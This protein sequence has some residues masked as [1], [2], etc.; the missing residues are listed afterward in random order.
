MSW[1]SPWSGSRPWSVLQLDLAQ[2]VMDICNPLEITS[3]I[4]PN[5]FCFNITKKSCPG[6]LLGQVPDLGV[7]YSWTSPRWSWTSENHLK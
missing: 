1:D 7:Y 3:F 5:N 2:M 6:T 4:I